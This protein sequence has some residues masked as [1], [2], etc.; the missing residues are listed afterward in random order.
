MAILPEVPD[1]V[2][3]GAGPVGLALACA[4]SE[5]G[6]SIVIVDAA[7]PTAFRDDSR[8]LALSFGTLSLLL[9]LGVGPL[10]SATP[11][12]TV[13]VSQKGHFGRTQIRASDEG[14]PYLGQV[15]RAR[16]LTQALLARVR[17]T[18]IP[19]HY[20]TRL[21]TVP[22]LNTA[23]PS[24]GLSF[25][26]DTPEGSLTHTLSP[27]LLALA[28][29][30]I[31]PN[32]SGKPSNRAHAVRESA[33]EQHALI[34]LVRP[35]T[36]HQHQAWERFTSQGPLALLP[37]GEDYAVVHTVP[38]SMAAV[39]M[40]L[41]DRDYLTHLE[42]AFGRPLGLSHC[43]ERAAWPLLLRYRHAVT[44]PGCVW[45]GNAAQT[46]HPVA[47]Q[48]FNLA[49]RDV[50]ELARQLPTS[51]T[52]HDETAWAHALARHE[53]ARRAD[54]GLT[55]RLTDGLVRLFGHDNSALATLRGLGLIGLDLISP[56]RHGLAHQLIWGLRSTGGWR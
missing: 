17:L 21:Q 41:D 33:Y 20:H 35:Q 40:A 16:D 46:L 19:I 8:I 13:H 53:R 22:A 39:L 49:L 44:A 11:I 42:A 18:H 3:V 28:E 1:V 5:H 7:A 38:S 27:R 43:R 48:G 24:S 4:L 9:R 37:F 26:Q 23:P 34:S 25:R 55:L 47:G 45:L 56:L 50:F 51:A 6:L 12:H 2:I 29:G 15:V 14:L 31:D 30:R 54:R 32:A 10:P 36:P 52:R